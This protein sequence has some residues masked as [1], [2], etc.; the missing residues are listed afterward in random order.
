[1][2]GHSNQQHEPQQGG[3]A[4]L[5]RSSAH[6]STPLDDPNISMWGSGSECAPLMSRTSGESSLSSKLKSSWRRLWTLMTAPFLI[7][8]AM[9][10]L[11]FARSKARSGHPQTDDLPRYNDWH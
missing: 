8:S 3:P 10:A 1:M 5:S 4:F 6:F 7:S 11:S 9:R 2:T